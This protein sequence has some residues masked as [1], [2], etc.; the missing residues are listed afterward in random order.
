MKAVA[1]ENELKREAGIGSN[2]TNSLIQ[3]WPKQTVI[4]SSS[5]ISHRPWPAC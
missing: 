3:I 2:L 4:N 5:Y 1:E